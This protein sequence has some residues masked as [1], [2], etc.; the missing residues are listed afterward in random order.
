MASEVIADDDDEDEDDDHDADLSFG[1]F[2]MQHPWDGSS[3]STS[4]LIKP[5]LEKELREKLIF[6]SSRSGEA[7]PR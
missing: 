4:R 2:Q 6:C 7:S 5:E 3:L 1:G